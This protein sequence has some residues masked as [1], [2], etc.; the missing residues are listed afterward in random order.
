MHSAF[1][2]FLFADFAVRVFW[3]TNRTYG[4]ISRVSLILLHY[5]PIV[6]GSMV[7]MFAFT[8]ERDLST[9]TETFL[10]V[11]AAFWACGLILVLCFP[12]FYARLMESMPAIKRNLRAF[13]ESLIAD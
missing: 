11:L 5:P 7:D 9:L 3:L 4:F 1:S 13:A 8:I 10:A 6:A 2:Y 12:P